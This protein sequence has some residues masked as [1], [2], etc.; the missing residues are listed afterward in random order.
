MRVVV[1]GLCLWLASA[2]AF[3]QDAKSVI[4]KVNANNA[5]VRTFVADVENVAQ[6]RA[7]AITSTGRMYYE[8]E[9]RFRMTASQVTNGQPS[10]DIGSN[11]S[12]FWFW[13]KKL[14]SRTMFYSSYKNLYQ[15]GLRDSMHPL[16]MI[17]SLGMGQID[18]KG[19][20]VYVQGNYVV[21]LKYAMNPRGEKCLRVLFIDPGKP[22]IA[23]QRT[24]SAD[25]RSLASVSV[26]DWF[27]TS[28][29]IYLPKRISVNWQSEGIR[30]TQTL[31]NPQINVR[32]PA[33]T[34]QMPNLGLQAVDMGRQRTDW[35]RFRERD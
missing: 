3:A 26:D 21:V 13:V 30:F 23:A 29:G 35:D 34:F 4:A 11:D 32:I 27:A 8:K 14:D 19:A 10:S 15:T 9:R 12:Y 7:L 2:S 17:E 25:Q 6:R 28:A 18:T 20:N 1:F 31:S 24:Y 22:A 33:E 16:W 5:Q